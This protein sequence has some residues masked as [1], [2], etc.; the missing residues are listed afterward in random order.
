MISKETLMSM[1]FQLNRKQPSYLIAMSTLKNRF[2]PQHNE[3]EFLRAKFVELQ[4]EMKERD[5]EIV[6]AQRRMTAI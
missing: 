2:T 3:L 4:S 6:F 1:T 5:K